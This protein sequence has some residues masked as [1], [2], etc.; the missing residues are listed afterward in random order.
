[1]GRAQGEHRKKQQDDD[2]AQNGCARKEITSELPLDLARI[3]F[4]VVPFFLQIYHENRILI[5][6]SEI[7][8]HCIPATASANTQKFSWA[9]RTLQCSMQDYGCEA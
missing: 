8:C 6:I 9:R 2:A 1:M 3:A 7:I 5:E 4:I